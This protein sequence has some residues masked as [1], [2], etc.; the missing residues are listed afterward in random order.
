MLMVGGPRHGNDVPMA[1]DALTFVDMVSATTYHRKR[2]VKVFPHPL[3]GRPQNAFTQE[4][5]V[6]ETVAS[7]QAVQL[8]VGDILATR[9]FREEGTEVPVEVREVD[10]D[11]APPHESNG[12]TP[13]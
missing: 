13:Q 11:Q 6:H 4:V 3:T 7:H 10:A 8:G 9:W 2:L 1:D 5:L 12:G